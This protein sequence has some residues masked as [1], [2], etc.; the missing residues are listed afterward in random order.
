M[1][2]SLRALPGGHNK[3]VYTHVM[4]IFCEMIILTAS[5]WVWLVLP[6][7]VLSNTDHVIIVVLSCNYW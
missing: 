6:V 2:S 7:R 5:M 3:V 4:E 1:I